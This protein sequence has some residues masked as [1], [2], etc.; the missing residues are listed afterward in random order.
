MKLEELRKLRKGTKLMLSLGSG[1]YQEVRYISLVQAETFGSFS[2]EDI[3]KDN[4]DF[5]KGGRK[6]MLA[7]IEYEDDKGWVKEDY[8]NPRRLKRMF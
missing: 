8:V 6:H 7:N 3:M 2:F 1:W 4:I 5:K